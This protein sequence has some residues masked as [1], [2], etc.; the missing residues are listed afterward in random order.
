M[1]AETD[2]GGN[3][4][5]E[6][7]KELESRIGAETKPEPKEPGT[8]EIETV[9]TP[10]PVQKAPVGAPENCE[11]YFF[12]AVTAIKISCAMK[13]PIEA[14]GAFR[15]NADA[16]YQQLLESEVPFHEWYEWIKKQFERKL[17][18][19]A[20][21]ENKPVLVNPGPPTPEPDSIRAKF[22]RFMRRSSAPADQ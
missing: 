15:V 7:E 4:L 22:A 6:L 10:K 3:I 12:L 8:E 5:S 13:A 9:A 14:T 2:S 1:S 16:L 17:E 20:P 18:S 11:E 19:F 21:K